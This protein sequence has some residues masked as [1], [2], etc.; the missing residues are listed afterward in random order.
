MMKTRNLHF[1]RIFCVIF[2]LTLGWNNVEARQTTSELIDAENSQPTTRAT[3]TQMMKLLGLITPLV[4]F[5]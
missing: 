4:M 3:V 5:R 1:I 2:T